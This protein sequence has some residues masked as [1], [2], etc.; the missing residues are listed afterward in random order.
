ML[1]SEL[2]E[3]YDK[4]NK[5]TKSIKC[6]LPVHIA[7]NKEETDLFKKNGEHNEQYYKWQ[8]LNTFVKAGLCSKDYI[9]TE[10]QFP[11]GNKNSA[12]IKLDG[13]IFDNKDWFMH[14]KKLHSKKDDTRW[15]ELNWLKEHLLCGIEFKK[16]DS[17][18]ITN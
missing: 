4:E 3:N 6:F 8:F 13:A 11:K 7:I 12:P 15:D 5:N 1:F 10:I 9:G 18:D 16:E 17:K 14:Y 2:K